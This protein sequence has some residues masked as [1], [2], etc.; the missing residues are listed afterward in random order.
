MGKPGRM[1]RQTGKVFENVA[2]RFEKF[3]D[4]GPGGGGGYD[5]NDF[6]Q[7]VAATT[8]DILDVFRGDA[9]GSPTPPT[10]YVDGANWVAGAGGVYQPRTGTVAL[11]SPLAAVP[12]STSPLALLGNAANT[13]PL[14]VGPAVLQADGYEVKVTVQPSRPLVKDNAGN[15]AS[16]ALANGLHVGALYSGGQLVAQ[17]L[18][19]IF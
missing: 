16:G 11:S 14:N 6:L 18:V 9:V 2:G 15:I 13:N 1:S 19:N 8:K 3:V 10:L 12:A 4:K 17:I 7:D 5:I